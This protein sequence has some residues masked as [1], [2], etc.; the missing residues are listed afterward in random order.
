M[1]RTARALSAAAG[2]LAL[3]AGCSGA[4]LAARD[5]ARSA[6][7]T[8][9]AAGVRKGHWSSNV[10]LSFSGAKV[11][12]KST[13]L[14]AY[15]RA[16]EYAVPKNPQGNLLPTA[17]TAVAMKDPSAAQD[18]NLTIT[19]SPTR[20]SKVTKTT[21]GMIGIMISGAALFNPYEADNK[22]V[23]TLANFTI[24]D[25][26]GKSVGF[27]DSC[28]GHPNPQRAY[29]YHALPT[30]ITARVDKPSGPSHLIGLALDGYP[31]YGD[32]D[33]RGHKIA[34]SKLDACNGITSATPEFPKGIYHYVLLNTKD[35]RSSIRCFRGKVTISKTGGGM[36]MMGM[37]P[38]PPPP[39]AAR[40][41]FAAAAGSAAVRLVCRL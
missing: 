18:Y 6:A 12:I 37:G 20:S 11:K 40:S 21:G 1:T 36:P 32:R 34:E 17:S 16:A 13:G 29:H 38:P 2:L 35:S 31:I 10:K 14:P 9:T 8:S 19:T 41:I 7:S 22:T 39:S 3:T 5:S 30:C 26:A 15:G 33:I 27:L 23:A 28:N 4:A 24:K 25:S